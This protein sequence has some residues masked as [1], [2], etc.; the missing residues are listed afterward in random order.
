MTE[1]NKKNYCYILYN[2]SNNLTYNG[3]TVNL[4]RRLRQHNCE[5]KGGAQYTTKMKNSKGIIWKYLAII[6]SD[7]PIFTPKKAL[8]IEWSIKYPTNIRPR[9]IKFN[10]PSGRLIGLELALKNPKF[11]NI[12]FRKEDFL[13]NTKIDVINSI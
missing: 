5:I 13:N 8:S 12:L 2:D 11:A 9:P 10:T 3:Y 6:T 1:I 4:E 7:D